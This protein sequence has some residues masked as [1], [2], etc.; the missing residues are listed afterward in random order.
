L[1]ENV[2]VD[3]YSIQGEKLLTK[4][5]NG[6]RKHEFSLSGRPAG[7]YFIHVRCGADS[8]TKKIIKQSRP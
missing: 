1:L 6:E 8:E 2:K 7:L 3:V 5:L 4:L